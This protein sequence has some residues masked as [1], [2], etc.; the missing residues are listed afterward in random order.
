LKKKS[1]DLDLQ[2]KI[3]SDWSPRRITVLGGKKESQVKRP[4]VTT[5]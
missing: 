3:D 2:R 5:S 1:D 4:L